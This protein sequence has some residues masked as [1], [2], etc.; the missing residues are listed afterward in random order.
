MNQNTIIAAL[1]ERIERLESENERLKAENEKPKFSVYEENKRL[2][3]ENNSLRAEIRLNQSIGEKIQL[4]PNKS[5]GCVV[6]DIVSR[7]ETPIIVSLQEYN[8]VPQWKN[9]VK[10]GLPILKEGDILIFKENPLDVNYK[11]LDC[12]TENDLK[13]ANEYLSDYPATDYII[14]KI[15]CN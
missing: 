11:M 6:A 12:P 1:V 5:I 9:S 14:I 15:Q 2:S 7:N 4:P 10:D 3:A 8:S 13:G